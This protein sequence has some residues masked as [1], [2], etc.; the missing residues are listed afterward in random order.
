MT[1]FVATADPLDVIVRDD[2]GRE[3]ERFER[4]DLTS[5]FRMDGELTRRGYTLDG[6][7]WSTKT[8]RGTVLL[9]RGMHK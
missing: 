5:L 8:I 6:G 7:G 2:R 3:V 4:L 1:R 9:A